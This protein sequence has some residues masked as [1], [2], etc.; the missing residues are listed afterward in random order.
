MASG[1]FL[2][3]ASKCLLLLAIM[4]PALSL[5]SIMFKNGPLSSR[6]LT[7]ARLQFCCFPHEVNFHDVQNDRTLGCCLLC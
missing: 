7:L 4:T 6:E 5:S 2:C 3:V 1:H